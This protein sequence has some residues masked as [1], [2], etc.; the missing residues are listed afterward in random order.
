MALYL[1][2]S[3]AGVKKQK[4]TPTP[5]KLEANT[6]N[7]TTGDSSKRILVLE[8]CITAMKLILALD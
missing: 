4:R 7:L 3:W 5:A 1:A 8:Q 2:S 6:F